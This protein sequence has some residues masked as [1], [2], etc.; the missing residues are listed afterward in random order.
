[1]K[2]VTKLIHLLAISQDWGYIE[3]KK[4]SAQPRYV[5][6]T[7]MTAKVTHSRSYYNGMRTVHYQQLEI[8]VSTQTISCLPPVIEIST[9]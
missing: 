3:R 8:L 2:E 9:P 7:N 1:M 5:S 6:T 4:M